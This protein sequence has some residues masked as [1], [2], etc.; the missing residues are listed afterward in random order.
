MT[1]T[2][3]EREKVE[4]NASRAPSQESSTI[5]RLIQKKLSGLLFAAV[6]A[7]VPFEQLVQQGMHNFEIKIRP[8]ARPHPHR[9]EALVDSSL[10]SFPK[11]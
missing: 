10:A 3:G 5:T 2:S 7:T 1:R 6:W 11:V 8:E 9:D 4:L